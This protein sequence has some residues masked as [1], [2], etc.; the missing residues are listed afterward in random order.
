[1]R[2]DEKLMR[3]FKN[4]KKITKVYD[5]DSHLPIVSVEDGIADMNIDPKVFDYVGHHDQEDSQ[6]WE[7]LGTLLQDRNPA[8]LSIL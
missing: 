4:E 2:R 6:Y 5:R 1:M 8:L 7:G 3:K